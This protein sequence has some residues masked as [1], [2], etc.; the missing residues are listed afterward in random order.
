M[1]SNVISRCRRMI[2]VQN[3]YR[4]STRSIG[5]GYSLASTLTKA[6]VNCRKNRHKRQTRSRKTL[7]SPCHP[8]TPPPTHPFSLLKVITL[9]S[10]LLPLLPYEKETHR[11]A[12]CL[13]NSGEGDD[14]TNSS[15]SSSKRNNRNSTNSKGSSRRDQTP[16][17]RR[18]PYSMAYSETIF[19]VQDPRARWPGN[20][21]AC[22]P[23]A[24]ARLQ[25]WSPRWRVLKKETRL[26][27][28]RISEYSKGW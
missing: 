2:A 5:G 4:T 18:W 10:R 6:K 25:D 1:W 16:A 24:R 23:K 28:T 26:S 19:W 21:D 15:S 13:T 22:H 3:L 11:L 7:L 12:P 9:P 8:S 27:N 14:T 17:A 20:S